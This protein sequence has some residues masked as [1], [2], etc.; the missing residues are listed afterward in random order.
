MGFGLRFW[1]F[2]FRD[3]ALIDR[4]SSPNALNRLFRVLFEGNFS[5]LLGHDLLDFSNKRFRMI[6]G[7]RT[8]MGFWVMGPVLL[9][10][11][12]PVQVIS[13]FFHTGQR[14]YSVPVLAPPLVK[15][16]LHSDTL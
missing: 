8:G 2:G 1:E 6:S 3:W 11:G 10:L 7:I 5:V 9:S 14:L 16:S 13:A 12:F 4:G 15:S